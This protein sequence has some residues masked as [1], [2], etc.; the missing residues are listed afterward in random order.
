MSPTHIDWMNPPEF[1]KTVNELATD[2]RADLLVDIINKFVDYVVKCDK[3][4]DDL[5]DE[6]RDLLQ[7]KA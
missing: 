1:R 5:G 3:I 6:I 4:R 2:K 7:E